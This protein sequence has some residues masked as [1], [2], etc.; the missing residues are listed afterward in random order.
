MNRFLF[1]DGH[2]FMYRSFFAIRGL[3][4]SQGRPTNA[5]FGFLKALRKMIADLAPTHGAVFWDCGLPERRTAL[6]P[7][8]KQQRPEMPGDLR[9][10]EDRIVALC[11]LLGLRS[12]SVLNVEADDLIASYSHQAPPDSEIIIA[13]ADKD[14]LQVVT[15]KVR[16]YSTAKTDLTTPE[17][18]RSGYALLGAA[19]VEAKWG[20]P[21]PAIRDV[22][23]LMGDASDN[24]PGVPGIGEKTACSLIRQFGSVHALLENLPK[25]A[26]E[27]LRAK[28]DAARD[29]IFANYEM[30]RLDRD[31]PLPVPFS[32]LKLIPDPAGY[33]AFL[34][35]CEFRSL[36]AETEETPTTPLAASGSLPPI[37][38]ELF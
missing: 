9:A 1:V 35:E 13:T 16:V 29:L 25:L 31:L 2:Y 34:R 27:K 15:D 11:P 14:I 30:V 33:N 12:I 26:N 18:A 4:D 32:E 24:I 20:V 21:A 22:L 17:A 19:E 7:A 38:G 23:A 36:L 8:Y 5:I 10:Q 28:I 6:Q 37:Q 3:R